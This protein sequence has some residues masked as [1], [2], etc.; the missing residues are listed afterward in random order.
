MTKVNCLL[1]D[2]D[3][4]IS[5]LNVPRQQSKVLP[6][7]EALLNIINKSIT[8]G[9]ITTKDLSFILPRTLFAHAWCAIAGL[10]MKIGSEI[11]VSKGV[12]EALPYLDR[13]LKFAREHLRKGGVVEEKCNINGNR[14]LFVSTGAR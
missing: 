7:L 9:I 14:W 8:I 4:T 13:A 5:P 12:E 6:H 3:G 1:L 2:Y 10:E 11:F